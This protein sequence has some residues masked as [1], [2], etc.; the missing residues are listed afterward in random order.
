[1]PAPTFALSVDTD[2]RHWK[3]LHSA[4]YQTLG[5]CRC[6]VAI[7]TLIWAKYEFFLTVGQ[8]SSL[9]Y[10]GRFEWPR[11]CQPQTHQKQTNKQTNKQNKKPKNK[12][13]KKKQQKQKYKQTTTKTNN[14][15]G[16]NPSVESV[17]SLWW[18]EW[19]ACWSV[20]SELWWDSLRRKV[21][22]RASSLLQWW[23]ITARRC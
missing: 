15:P 12:P 3:E 17:L 23:R 9:E 14:K 7:H 10:M 6:E 22:W 5:L 1:M 18:C 2:L 20:A 13:K 8:A 11:L 19:A 21:S 16:S 4:K